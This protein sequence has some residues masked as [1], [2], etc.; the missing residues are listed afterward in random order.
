[1]SGAHSSRVLGL[2]FLIHSGIWGNTLPER[3]HSCRSLE[4]RI[5]SS[6]FRTGPLAVEN[7]YHVS[8]SLMMEGSWTYSA[9]PD[10]DM[11]FAA[12]ANKPV[13]IAINPAAAANKGTADFEKCHFMKPPWPSDSSRTSKY[14]VLSQHVS[15][16]NT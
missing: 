10:T 4:R 14:G 2:C 16:M 3:F 11:T 1:M 15:L 9:S 6:P 8:P 5:G 12:C 13:P 7:K